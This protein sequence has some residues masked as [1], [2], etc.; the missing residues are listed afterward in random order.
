MYLVLSAERDIE[1]RER[2]VLRGALRILT[3]GLVSTSSMDELLAEFESARARDGV[4]VRLDALAA[5][6][7]GD[8]NDAEL[9]LGLM[10]AAA[11]TD[12][13]LG[14]A[15]QAIILALGERL[16]VAT[17]HVQNLLYGAPQNRS[18]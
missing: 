14:T 8:P 5:A 12:G 4:D 1:E 17:A 11:E 3:D 16:G 13:R 10:A 6:L 18:D 7:Y 15:E 2:D 9:A